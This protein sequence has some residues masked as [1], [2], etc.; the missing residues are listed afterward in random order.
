MF[1][2]QPASGSAP[3]WQLFCQ[4]FEIVRD[5]VVHV[6]MLGPLATAD[7]DAPPSRD[8]FNARDYVDL[9]VNP[10][11]HAEWAVL[12]GP[13]PGTQGIESEAERQAIR[14]QSAARDRALKA[15]DWTKRLDVRRRPTLAYVDADACGHAGVYGWSADRAEVL[16]VHGSGAG[17]S[18]AATFDIA[19]QSAGFSI[20]A[21][22]YAAPQRSF[23]LCSDVSMSPDPDLPPPETWHAVGGAI[24]IVVSPPGLRSRSPE[25]QLATVTLSNVVFRNAAGA[26]L[27]VQGPV[28]LVAFVRSA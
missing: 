26:T 18:Q 7:G 13:H 2:W 14:D 8:S 6:E 23:D 27:S 12:T 20:D 9:R 16:V 10:Q 22:V 17:W 3:S 24:T 11:G 21:R 15:V 28:T 25:L 19:R 5:Q 1:V 4:L